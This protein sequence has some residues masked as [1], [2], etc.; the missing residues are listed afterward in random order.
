MPVEC[1]FSKDSQWRGGGPLRI[2]NT[3]PAMQDDNAGGRTLDG[4]GHE[5]HLHLVVAAQVEIER[6]EIRIE[7]M[8]ALFSLKSAEI[9]QRGVLL[10][11]A[12]TALPRRAPR[13]SRAP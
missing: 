10:G 11:S 13:G 7:S 1:L 6:I 5:R 3:P 8:H 4:C 9:G 12:C 2:L